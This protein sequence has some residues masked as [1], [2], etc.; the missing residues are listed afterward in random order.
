MS[1][2]KSQTSNLERMEQPRLRAAEFFA[3]IGL[4][5]QALAQASID[6]V[7]ANDIEECKRDIYAENFGDDHFHLGDV[8][9]VRGAD[10]PD[11]DVATASFPCT[12]LSLAGNRKGIREGESS[13]FWE[14][15]RVL[16]EMGERRPRAVLLEN[17]PGF[18]TSKGG[19]DLRDALAELNGLG[20]SCDVMVLNASRFV[21]QSRQRLFIVGVQGEVQSSPV[22]GSPLRPAWIVDLFSAPGSGLRLH[23]HTPPLPAAPDVSFG[24]VADRLPH[25]SPLWWEA[26]RL[27]AFIDSLSPLQRERLDAMRRGRRLQWRTAYRRTRAGV[28]V[29]EIRNDELAGCLRT[30][31]GGSSKQAVVEAGNGKVRVRWMTASEY[32]ALQG[33]PGF[34]F[35]SVTENKALFGFGDA[36]CVPVVAWLAT[37]YL[38]PIIGTPTPV[39]A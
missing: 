3:G 32:A 12:D 5:R 20:Y 21:P 16:E 14:F 23:C 28:A 15:A 36:V 31:R 29:W 33:A 7:W 17:V 1:V 11:I 6:V 37:A 8:R 38:A 24:S 19:R 34:L 39:A 30:A 27:A 4:V 35:S 18:A 25:S 13:M 10:I 22:E 9:D 2:S 26:A